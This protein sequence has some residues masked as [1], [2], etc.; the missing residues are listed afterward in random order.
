MRAGLIPFPVKKESLDRNRSFGG[1][2]RWFASREARHFLDR[3]NKIERIKRISQIRISCSLTSYL[4]ALGVIFLIFLILLI[5]S[6]L[7]SLLFLKAHG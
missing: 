3:I 7:P 2:A 4:E 1:E 6:K 5:M